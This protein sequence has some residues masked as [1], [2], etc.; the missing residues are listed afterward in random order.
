M[1]F[2]GIRKVFST[3]D[4]NQYEAIG[5]F[6][7]SL[8]DKYG[9]SNLR[10]LGYNWTDDS[11]EYIIGLKSGVIKGADCFVELPDSGWVTVQGKTA[12]LSEIY[13]KIYQNGVLLFEIETFDDDGNCQIM[14][15]RWNYF[16]NKNNS[17]NS[18]S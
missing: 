12:N 14:Y 2:Y 16:I 13:E 3:I 17:L 15:Y 5:D 6:W 18:S 7:N 4:D 8:S 10:G 11:I 1:N 9:R